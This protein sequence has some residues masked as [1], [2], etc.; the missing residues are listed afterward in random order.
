VAVT[1]EGIEGLTTPLLAAGARSVVATQWRIGDRS[2]VRLVHDFYEQLA[3]GQPVAEAL[4]S[5]KL[6][7]LRRGGPAG[8][9]PGFTV[10][11]DPWERVAVM[12]PSTPDSLRWAAALA[13]LIL[14]AGVGYWAMRRRHRGRHRYFPA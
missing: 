2:T 6:A 11:G 3:K 4:R 10:V 8:E 7:A 12:E 9:W 14:L 13:A 5:A 1:G